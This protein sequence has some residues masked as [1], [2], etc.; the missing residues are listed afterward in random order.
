MILTALK[1]LADVEGLVAD[2]DYEPK[3]VTHV[4]ELASKGQLLGITDI[5]ELT[6]K[7]KP[8]AVLRLVPKTYGRTSGIAAQFLYDKSDY[9][10]GIKKN[11]DASVSLTEERLGASLEIIERAA[12]QS[13][14]D[15]L[16][17]VRCFLQSLAE[18]SERAKRLAQFVDPQDLNGLWFVFRLHG[19][20]GYVSERRKVREW[21]KRERTSTST[22]A[23]ATCLVTGQPCIPVAKH[24]LIKHLRGPSTSGVSIVSF[25]SEAFESYGLSR[26]DNAPVSRE[27]AETYVQALNRLLSPAWPKPGVVGE[28]LPNRRV[29]LS[30]NTTVVFWTED[31]SNGFADLFNTLFEAADEDAVRRLFESPKRGVVPY[32][33]DKTSF[34]VLTLSGGQGRATIRGWLSATV[35]EMAAR[36][37]HWFDDLRLESGLQ[38]PPRPSI[39][40]LLRSIAAFGKDENIAPN[41]AAEVF[42]AILRDQPLPINLMTAA[43]RRNK[44]EGPGG[45]DLYRAHLRMQLLKATLLRLRRG[46][47]DSFSHLPEVFPMLD[48]S[49]TSPAYRLGRLFAVLEKLQ[50]D[51]QGQT[52][53]TIGDR[54]YGSAS[55]APATAFPRLLGLSRHHL[56][57][58]R[59]EKPG[60]AVNLDRSLGEILD[61]I[62]AERLPPVLSME[63]QGLFALGYYHQRQGFFRKKEEAEPEKGIEATA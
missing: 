63:E 15:G 5:R 61:G 51:A 45:S 57:K 35:A 29:I 23:T 38:E 16:A 9:T 41:L 39:K 32:M 54:F 30:D 8:K 1:E 60:W 22:D 27:A 47:P 55:T 28:S 7:G 42:N 37:Q 59:K 46:H 26:N 48:D 31:P 19:D 62:S 56:A 58:L 52:N 44:A 3:P 34:Y 21:W 49:N 10:L 12:N 11:K 53:A 25:N 50:G 20:E 2:P 13:K 14:D 36:M 18:D 6:K 33:D 4:I 24:D 43:I 17:A 40:A